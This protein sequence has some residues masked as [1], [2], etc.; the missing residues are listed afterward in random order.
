MFVLR[1]SDLVIICANS[2]ACHQQGDS[3]DEPKQH[4]VPQDQ[5]L[6]LNVVQEKRHV[7][8]HSYVY[9]KQDRMHQDTSLYHHQQRNQ[10][11]L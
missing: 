5:V 8:D 1:F 7:S 6:S 10:G 3:E 11:D 4:D 9:A 2:N